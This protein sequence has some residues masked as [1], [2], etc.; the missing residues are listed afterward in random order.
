MLDTS[1]AAAMLPRVRNS[2]HEAVGIATTV[3]VCAAVAA[4]P[5][6]CA[7]AITAALYASWM[8][9]V[10]QSDTRIHRL[11]RLERRN[12]LA[13]AVG[14]VL[15]APLR[16][17][18]LVAPHRGFTHWLLTGVLVT[19]VA[20]VLVGAVA[21][22]LAAPVAL[23]VA[24]GYLMHALADACTPHGAPLLGPFSTRSVHLL[25]RGLRITTGGAGDTAVLIVATVAAAYVA[26]TQLLL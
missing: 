16:L 14:F 20:A 13:R 8:P 22:S 1:A 3:G 21:P 11:T 2:T 15:R 26:L 23:G 24:C 12:V 17:L 6:S 25:P 5:L 7:A 4:P 18:A 9:D 10:D 19:A